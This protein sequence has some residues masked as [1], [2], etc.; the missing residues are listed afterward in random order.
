MVVAIKMLYAMA[1][2]M[3]KWWDQVPT[4]RVKSETTHP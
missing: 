2:A 1:K 3:A 4:G